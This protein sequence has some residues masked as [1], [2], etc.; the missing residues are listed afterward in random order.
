V[1]QTLVARGWLP[2]EEW[3]NDAQQDWAAPFV[4]VPSFDEYLRAHPE[5]GALPVPIDQR[6]AVK[7]GDLVVY[8]WDADGSLDHIEVVARIEPRPDGGAAIA[9]L[10]HSDVDSWY[11]DLDRA[12]T[13]EHPGAT[14]YFWTIP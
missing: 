11:R 2:N 5:L 7:P 14:A 4:H 1:S 6:D 10:G 13:V 8:D 9:T 12:I 3:F